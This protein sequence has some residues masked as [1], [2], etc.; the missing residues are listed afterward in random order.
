MNLLYLNNP[1]SMID[2]YELYS[3]M[4]K[5]N[6]MLS[7]QGGVSSELLTSILQIMDS[8]TPAILRR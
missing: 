2:T 1:K 8:S 4:E 6:V 7:F 3:M 5:H